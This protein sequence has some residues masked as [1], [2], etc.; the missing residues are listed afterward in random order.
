MSNESTEII[1]TVKKY[2]HW[3][4]SQIEYSWTGYRDSID[5]PGIGKYKKPSE[6]PFIKALVF[7]INSTESFYR[8]FETRTGDCGDQATFLAL[9]LLR[10]PE[11]T[12][13]YRVFVLDSG[14]IL[15]HAVVILIPKNSPL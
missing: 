14:M 4:S 15:A 2:M 3:L 10:V 6:E 11:I 12:K 13:E 1:E 8:M 7:F 9:M 5:R